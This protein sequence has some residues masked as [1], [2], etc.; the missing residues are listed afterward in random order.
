VPGTV[1][2]TCFDAWRVWGTVGPSGSL[3]RKVI[4]VGVQG[5]SVRIREASARDWCS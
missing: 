2:G 3:A 5:A 1:S 4:R